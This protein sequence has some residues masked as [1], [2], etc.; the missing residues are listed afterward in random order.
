MYLL[1][2]SPCNVLHELYLS[3]CWYSSFLYGIV[4]TTFYAVVQHYML[5]VIL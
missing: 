3:T 1:K 5:L 4:V 2:Y